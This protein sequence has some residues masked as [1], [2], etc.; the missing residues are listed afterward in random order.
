MTLNDN[1]KAIAYK[2]LKPFAKSSAAAL[3]FFTN[4]FP[5]SN[6]IIEI[7]VKV[8]PMI[9]LVIF[10]N[11]MSKIKKF[12]NQKTTDLILGMICSIVGDICLV[13]N[14]WD[15][16]GKDMFLP[17]VGAFALGHVFYIKSFGLKW[18]NTAILGPLG[19]FGYFVTSKFDIDDEIL[20]VAVHTYVMIIL[21]MVWRGCS[22]C[23]F[24][25]LLESGSF[26]GSLFFAVSDS[27]LGLGKFSD[28]HEGLNEDYG[29]FVY[30]WMI[31][32]TYILGQVGIAVSCLNV[33]EIIDQRKS[34]KVQ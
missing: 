19:C 2:K 30:G 21:V 17:G 28:V 22:V 12:N 18:D 10:M 20:N 9:T 4:I 33:E 16:M 11:N 23:E 5:F 7:M 31:Y 13:S 15:S 24:T 32:F 8:L 25:G 26:W 29:V 34:K 3:I 6:P 27:M 1:L 14:F